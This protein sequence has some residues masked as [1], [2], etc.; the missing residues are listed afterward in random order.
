MNFGRL[1]IMSESSVYSSEDNYVLNLSHKAIY[2]IGLTWNIRLQSEFYRKATDNSCLY[3]YTTRLT[4][5]V[6]L[7][8]VTLGILSSVKYRV[9][10]KLVILSF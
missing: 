8:M 5:Q 7:R 2:Q 9:S 4:T 3:A 10:I 1:S 6:A